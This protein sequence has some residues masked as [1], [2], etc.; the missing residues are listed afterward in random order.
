MKTTEEMAL[1][2]RVLRLERQLKQQRLLGAVLALAAVAAVGI[3]AS[4]ENVAAELR[5]KRLVVVNDQGDNAVVL[6][7]EPTGGVGVFYGA[8][9]RLPMV[10]MGSLP[11]GGEV[12]LKAPGG[13]DTVQLSSDKAGG[14]VLVST[15]GKLH[16]IGTEMVK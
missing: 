7:A 11:S 6:S 5:T 1:E 15:S 3:A 13:Q 8:Q 12:L 16:P 2:T 4:N 9:G 14:R 10:L